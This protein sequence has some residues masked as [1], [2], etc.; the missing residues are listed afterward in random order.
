MI[1]LATIGMALYA[2]ACILSLATFWI[3]LICAV[4]GGLLSWPASLVAIAEIPW[5]SIV[6][7]LPYSNWLD[8]LIAIVTLIV[9]SIF[10]VNRALPLF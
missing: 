10:S 9:S 3:G 8:L 4:A 7:I 2:A 1:N 6:P 5:K